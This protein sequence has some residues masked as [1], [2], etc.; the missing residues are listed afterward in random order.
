[1]SPVGLLVGGRETAEVTVMVALLRGINVGGRGKLP[2]ADLRAIATDL[3]YDDVATYIQ[4]GNLVLTSR[5][6]RGLG[7]EG[8]GG[9]HRRGG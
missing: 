5:E 8:P 2:M 9:G 3:G 4:S 6:Q 7:G 1:M